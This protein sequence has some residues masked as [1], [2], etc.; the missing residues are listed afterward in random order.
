V[1][2]PFPNSNVPRPDLG[3]IDGSIE[4]TTV[5]YTIK[6]IGNMYGGMLTNLLKLKPLNKT[7]PVIFSY[8]QP[9]DLVVPIDSGKVY[10]GLSWCMTN[11]YNCYAIANTPR[12]YGSRTFSNWNTNNNHGYTIH[13]EF[14][15][16]NFPFNFLFGT[17][18][19]VDQANN[20]CH[21]YDNALTRET[22]LAAYF[23]PLITTSPLCK[24]TPVGINSFAKS[25][26]SNFRVY[27]QPASHF[28]NLENKTN[29]LGTL[30]IY[31][32]LGQLMESP[33]ML[34]NSKTLINTET[35]SNGVYFFR[36]QNEKG[37]VQVLKVVIGD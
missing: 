1:G 20:P 26:T 24:N 16:T 33:R 32:A 3:S 23:A 35:W 27:P 34:Q 4:P 19:C 7:K 9:C 37:E 17:G 12:V 10:A 36:L 31:S 11:G 18:S 29:T 21:A 28:V 25:E 5:K 14:T 22:N 6:G 13:N 15:S 30:S 8:H 2:K